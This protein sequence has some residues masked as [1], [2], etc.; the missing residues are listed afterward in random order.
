MAK[1][2][3]PGCGNVVEIKIT[4]DGNMITKSCPRCGYIFIKYQVKSVNQA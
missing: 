2:T 3:C 1:R 4:K